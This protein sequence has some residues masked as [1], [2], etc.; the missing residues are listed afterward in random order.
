MDVLAGHRTLRQ[1][2]NL[3]DTGDEVIQIGEPCQ[4]VLLDE[5]VAKAA[6]AAVLAAAG[7]IQ[8]SHA[9]DGGEGLRMSGP[10][11]KAQCLDLIEAG[12]QKQ[13]F[14]V[15]A[16]E[17][18]GFRHGIQ[19]AEHHGND[20]L[21]GGANLHPH[22][23]QAGIHHESPHPQQFSE[24]DG[25]LWIFAGGN[26]SGQFAHGHLLRMAG[27]GDVHQTLGIDRGQH[28]LQSLKDEAGPLVGGDKA[29]GQHTDAGGAV[30]DG[31]H[32]QNLRHS[33]S[34]VE[35]GTGQNQEFLV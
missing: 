16:E 12:G 30:L 1:V 15:V 32:L 13:G 10:H 2:A 19:T 21:G 26:E 24:A 27:A 3:S 31:G 5:L 28:F 8:V 20:I 25:I 22:H 34:K 23:I 6:V 4:Q 11:G 7:D 29:L 14:G 18:G 17:V 9:S 33:G 35:G